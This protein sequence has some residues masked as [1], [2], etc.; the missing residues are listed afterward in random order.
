MFNR[1]KKSDNKITDHED[2]KKVDSYYSPESDCN[3]WESSRVEAIERSEGRAGVIAK[4]A[5]LLVVLLVVAIISMLPLKE[6]IPYLVRVDSS[7]GIPDIINSLTSKE[8]THPDAWNKHWMVEYVRHR[9]TYNWYTLQG[10]YDYVGLFSSPPIAQEYQSLFSGAEALDQVYGNKITVKVK[11]VS[12]VPNAK[13]TTKGVDYYSGTVRFKKTI[14]R[15][16][17]KGKG[18]STYWLATITFVYNNPKKLKESER[19]ENPFGLQVV[20]YRVDPELIGDTK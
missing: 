8:I 13:K 5:V 6:K 11:I 9:E 4:I 16:K 12:V 7:T 17:D 19:L 1:K 15:V 10:D 3:D 20:D 2:S 18:K 14:K